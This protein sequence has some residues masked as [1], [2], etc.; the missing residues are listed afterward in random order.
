[1]ARTKPGKLDER[2]GAQGKLDFAFAEHLLA[3]IRHNEPAAKQVRD[4]LGEKLLEQDISLEKLVHS[5]H[6]GKAAQ[7]TS[8]S[9]AV[10][11]LKSASTLDWDSI[12]EK[13]SLVNR[14]LGADEVYREMDF[15]SRNHYRRQVQ[16][17]AR[18]LGTRETRVAKLALAKAREEEGYRGHCGYYLIAEGRRDLFAPWGLK[19]GAKMSGSLYIAL[20]LALSLALGGAVAAAAFPLGRGWALTP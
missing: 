7:T 6:Q 19:S 18:K 3:V 1:M 16:L 9:N 14:I 12:F 20:N 11:S 10:L 15:D 13:L 17:L 2:I 5:E 8:M 4:L